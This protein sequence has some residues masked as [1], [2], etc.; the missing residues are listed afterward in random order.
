MPESLAYYPNIAALS[1]DSYRDRVKGLD[2][3]LAVLAALNYNYSLATLSVAKF[4][5]VDRSIASARA[6][7]EL[8]MVLLL[9]VVLF[10]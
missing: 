10:Q 3:R 4:R 5:L 2:Y 7:F 1:L 9:M 6:T 8:W